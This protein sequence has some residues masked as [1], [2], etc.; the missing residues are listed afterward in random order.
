MLLRSIRSRLIGLVV[1]TVVPFTALDRRRSV[2]PMAHRP[3]G[4]HSARHQ[5]SPPDRGPG[6]RPHQQPQEPAVRPQ[7]R[8][9]VGPQGHRGQR[10]PAAPGQGRAAALCR[11]PA[12]CS[13]STA[14]TS[15]RHPTTGRFFAGDRDYLRAILD[16]SNIAVSEVIRSRAGKE[17]VVT[18]RPAD[19]RYRRQVAR[20]ARRRHAARAFPGGAEHRASPARQRGSDRRSQ[21]GRHRAQRRWPELDRPRLSATPPRSPGTIAAHDISEVVRWADGVER[22][23]GSAKAA[24]VPWMVSVGLPTD[25]AFATVMWRLRVGLMLHLGGAAAR[26]RHRLDAVRQGSCARCGSLARMHPRLPPATSA[27]ARACRPM[28]RSGCSRRRSTRWPP[29]SQQREEDARRAADDLKQA[30]DTLSAVIDASPVAIVCSDPD[31]RIFLWN[32]AAE[33]IFGYTAEEAIGQHA[34]EMPPP[35]ELDD[36]RAGQARAQRRDRARSAPQAAAQGRHRCRRACRGGGHVQ[37]RRH[38]T[39]RRARLRRHHRADARRRAAQ[40]H[41]PLRPAHRPAQPP[42]AAEGAGPIAERKRRSRR[43]SRCSISTASRTSTIR[44]AIRPATSC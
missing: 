43:Q 36:R 2:E 35:V 41:R 28:A 33:R 12:W 1:A 3:G 37:R 39:R 30:K 7:R 6:R 38:G 24:Q 10:P 25:A 18:H 22:I 31:R 14:P 32:R 15:A 44:S 13:R 16:G 23:T 9:V 11:Q 26:L 42:H 40:A 29:R 4:R 20:R 19:R 5:R 21:P 17:W 8:G 27:T 34:R